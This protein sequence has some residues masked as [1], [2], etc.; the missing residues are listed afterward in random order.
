MLPLYREEGKTVLV[1]AVG[2]TGGRHRS[3]A[4]ARALAE[5]IGTLGYRV[6]ETHRDMTR[7]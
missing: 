4:V 7:T 1:V 3:V 6:T 2:C 5:Y